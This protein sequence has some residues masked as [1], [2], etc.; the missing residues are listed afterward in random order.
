MK[1]KNKDKTKIWIALYLLNKRN[2]LNQDL[3]TKKTLGP[4]FTE[5]CQTLNE[6]ITNLTLILSESERNA[7]QE[8]LFAPK[9]L[10]SGFVCAFSV[11]GEPSCK[12]EGKFQKMA[13]PLWLNPILLSYKILSSCNCWTLDFFFEIC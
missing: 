10:L 8:Y 4:R 1:T 11:L 2:I 6:E 9:P 3:P 12:Q 5:F 7:D 13:E